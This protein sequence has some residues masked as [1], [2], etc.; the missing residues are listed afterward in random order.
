[1]TSDI[2]RSLIKDLQRSIPLDP[3]N[4]GGTLGIGAISPQFNVPYNQNISLVG[5][6]WDNLQKI[7]N[8]QTYIDNGNVYCLAENDVFEGDLTVIDS[9]TG[10]LGT[11]KKAD[12]LITIDPV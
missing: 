12:R 4:I 9:A 5:S 11:P 8:G 6:T 1:M 2:I 7:T 10:L 3:T